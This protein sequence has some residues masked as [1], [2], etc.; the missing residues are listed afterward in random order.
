[1]TTVIDTRYAAAL[2]PITRRIRTDVTAVKT[3]TGR[4]AWTR[5]PLTPE[6]LAKHCNGGPARGVC[7]IKAGE[8]VTL[9]ALLDFDSH[10]GEV[11]WP[12]MSAAVQRVAGVLEMAWDAQ[13]ILWKSSGGRGVH[14][15]LLWEHPQDAYSVRQW[16]GGV[17][18]ACGLRNGSGGVGAGQVEVFPKQDS[19]AADGFGNQFILPL[20]GQSEPLVWDDL[21]ECLVG[22]GREHAL[23]MEWPESDDVPLAA[24]AAR[25]EVDLTRP[26]VAGQGSAW[27]AA[28]DAIPNTSEQSLSYDDWRNVVFGIHHETGGSDEGLA[29]AHAFSARCVAK[30]D[31]E[32]LDNR[33]WPYVRGGGERG[34]ASIT[35]ATICMVAGR[36]GWI[37][38]SAQP[39]M[40]DWGPVDPDTGLPQIG[41][42][43]SPGS[44]Q[45]LRETHS[46]SSHHEQD[47]DSGSEP[48]VKRRVRRRG[49]P[50]AQHRCTDQANANRMVSA[51]GTHLLVATTA[52]HAWTGARWEDDEANVYQ[53]TCRL[54][55]I[56][57]EE[58]R[59]VRARAANGLAD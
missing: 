13:P 51:Y 19:V 48:E 2:A 40:A 43:G 53:H 26:A 41:G 54:S 33:V 4:Q 8:S 37:L 15:M 7:P 25:A 32:F 1:M 29:L 24:R 30:Y 49:V 10:G 52:W 57:K 56:V 16:L 3:A 50:E 23:T 55:V 47:K 59:A 20:A 39:D 6:R 46:G 5:D 31:P 18:D 36:Y 22:L 58:A 45:G 27:R 14:L 34:S 11:D 44:A 42:D 12:A 17:L 28:L 38:P 35:G 9:V 21:A